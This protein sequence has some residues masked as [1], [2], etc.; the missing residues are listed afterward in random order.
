MKL[1]KCLLALL[2]LSFALNAFA[3][4]D[5]EYM[6]FSSA[7]TDGNMKVVKKYI[8][9]D[10]ALVNQ[11]FF[12]WEPLQMAASK[13]QLEVVKYLIAKGADKDYMHPT[14]HN[15]A[16]HLAAFIGDVELLKYLASVG[17]DVN[18]KLKDN[19][20]LIRYFREENDPKMVEL[21]TKL[22]T[23]DDG[24]QEEKCFTFED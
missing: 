7:I 23:K 4:T 3:L 17:V 14:S 20:S 1:F 8:E 13:G 19:V 10:P 18:K 22:G 16:F 2:S 21:L 6:E 11:K 15:T 12:A 5:D 9:A 24:C